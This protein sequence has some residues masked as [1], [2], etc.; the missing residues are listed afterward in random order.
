MFREIPEYSRFVANLYEDQPVNGTVYKLNYSI[1][2]I[3]SDLCSSVV[4]DYYTSCVFTKVN[5]DSS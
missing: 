3:K 1:L 2:F 5:L 4:S